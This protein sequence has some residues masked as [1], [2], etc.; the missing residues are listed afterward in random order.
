VQLNEQHHDQRAPWLEGRNSRNM[1][2][3]WQQRCCPQ[4]TETWLWE[5]FAGI[6]SRVDYGTCSTTSNI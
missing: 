1:H 4:G 3:N 6:R 2:A 5:N